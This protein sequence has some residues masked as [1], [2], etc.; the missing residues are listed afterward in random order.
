MKKKILV[1]CDSPLAPS[2]FG[3]VANEILGLVH[4]TYKCDITIWAINHTGESD[5]R[6][7]IIDSRLEGSPDRDE[8][9]KQLNK[10]ALCK[11]IMNTDFDVFFSIEDSFQMQEISTALA[12]KRAMGANFKSI[13]YFPVDAS[14]IPETWCK[15]AMSFDQPVV[16]TNFGMEQLKKHIPERELERVTIAYHG[17]NVDIFKPLPEEGVEVFRKEELHL[18]GNQALFMNLNKNQ[19]RKDIPQTMFAFQIFMGWWKKQEFNTPKP[20]LLLHMHPISGPG[21]NLI[22]IRD[23]HMKDVADHIIFPSIP[24]NGFTTEEINM[25]YN[26]ADCS[27]SSNRGEGWGFQLSESL[28]T[29]TPVIMPRNTASIEIL[30]EEYGNK[31]DAE[32]GKFCVSGNGPNGYWNWRFM[33]RSSQFSDPPR[34]VTDPVSLARQMKRVFIDCTDE[35]GNRLPHPKEGT[36]TFKQVERGYEWAQ[37]YTWDKIFRESWEPIFNGVLDRRDGSSL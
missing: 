15:T 12:R 31:G 7:T 6:F 25:F 21:E 11:Y 23:E 27:V 33:D 19:V 17:T 29:K 9:D 8:R 2:G 30:G 18:Y 36:E 28:A 26:A 10:K 1:F 13:F 5:E 14:D 34:P 35:G 4:K 20:K 3:R 22:Y 16:Y 24:P 32:R 37:Q